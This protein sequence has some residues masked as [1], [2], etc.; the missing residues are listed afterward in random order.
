MSEPKMPWDQL[1]KDGKDRGFLIKRLYAVNT[2]PSNGL[3]PV[4]AVLDEHA[5]Y[6]VHLEKLA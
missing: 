5:A 3:G 1:I 4:L 6:Q 2:V